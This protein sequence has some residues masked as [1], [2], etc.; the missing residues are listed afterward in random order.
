M[1][2]GCSIVR[3]LGERKMRQ[4]ASSTLAGVDIKRKWTRSRCHLMSPDHLIDKAIEAIKGWQ[5]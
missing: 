4:Q 5:G 2:R 3:F 1:F